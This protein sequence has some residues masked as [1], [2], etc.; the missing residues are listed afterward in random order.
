LQLSDITPQFEKAEKEYNEA[1]A[2]SEK[3]G[4]DW[5]IADTKKEGLLKVNE[6]PREASL[7]DLFQGDEIG[8]YQLIDISKVQMFFFT[9]AVI[10][11][12]GVTLGNLVENSTTVLHPFGVSL[13]AFSTTLNALLGISHAGYLTVKSVGHTKTE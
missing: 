13:P 7:N 10:I 4:A 12:Y 1:K 11:S 9:F 3:L 8:N 6:S 5:E 2:V